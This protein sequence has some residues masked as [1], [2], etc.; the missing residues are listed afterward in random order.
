MAAR[1][2]ALTGR[3]SI[4]TQNDS[5]RRS[6]IK[7]CNTNDSPVKLSPKRPKFPEGR[8]DGLPHGRS[9]VEAVGVESACYFR[10]G[11]F[12]CINIVEFSCSFSPVTNLNAS[13]RTFSVRNCQELFG[14]AEVSTKPHNRPQRCTDRSALHTLHSYT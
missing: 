8:E 11:S 5:N 14:V 12:Y 2:T 6:F 13:K 10:D 3:L 4:M 9:V 1:I 7:E